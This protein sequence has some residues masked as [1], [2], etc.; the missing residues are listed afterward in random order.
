MPFKF[1][2]NPLSKPAHG[3][4]SKNVR[5]IPES[6]TKIHP[7]LTKEKHICDACRK[8]IASQKTR[9]PNETF[10]V[11]VKCEECLGG[12][13]EV[14]DEYDENMKVDQPPFENDTEEDSDMELSKLIKETALSHIN[15]CLT[16]LDEPP[17]DIKQ[18]FSSTAQ[19]RKIFQNL[20]TIL[21]KKIF[22]LSELKNDENEIIDR[23]QKKFSESEDRLLKMKILTILPP[24]WSIAKIESVFGATNY[25]GRKAKKFIS[26][27]IF[28]VLD[29][30][31]P[32]KT[33][34]AEVIVQV[35]DFYL[36]DNNSRVMPGG[37]D[38]IT[39]RTGDKKAKLQKR[40][41]LCNLTELYTWSDP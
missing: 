7:T 37:N 21:E 2:C 35:K 16:I 3:K 32:G 41:V 24:S 34:P 20:S 39:V 8:T 15:Q 14:V 25:M 38:V 36:S 13:E 27:D 4:V 33:L 30:L 23:L 31:R 22:D 9:F 10:S 29:N 5:T 28:L 1:C 6:I 18:F 17:I 19:K 40:L 26:D 11:F 12:N